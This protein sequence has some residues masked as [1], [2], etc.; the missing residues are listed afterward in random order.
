[1]LIDWDAHIK[2]IE[3]KKVFAQLVNLL[4]E[5]QSKKCES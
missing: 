1:M 4:E 5:I 2:H 3:K